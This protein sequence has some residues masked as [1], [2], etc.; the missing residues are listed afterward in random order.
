MIAAEAL[1]TV[2]AESGWQ[3]REKQ[4]DALLA[5]SLELQHYTVEFCTYNEEELFV[6][7]SLMQLPEKEETRFELLKGAAALCA[8]LWQRH[9]INLTVSG[10]TLNLELS[11]KTSQE[12]FRE[13]IR[14]FLD[15]CD[16]FQENLK[17][18]ATPENTANRLS[19]FNA[20]MM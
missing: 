17:E 1:K 13:K 7:V 5:A 15:D 4:T 6:S 20:L 19:Q 2:F 12:D 14:V 16:Y 8:L 3:L 11:I 9:R 18:L 10:N